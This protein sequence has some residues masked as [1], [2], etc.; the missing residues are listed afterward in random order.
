MI[1]DEFDYYEAPSQQVFDEIKKKAIELWRTYDNTYGYV[2]EKLD[3]IIHIEN[4]KDNA[5]YI[6]GMF[7]SDNQ[8]KLVDMLEEPAQSKVKEMLQWYYMQILSHL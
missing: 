8:K 2:D 1:I 3:R 6:V 5:W 7:D 4:F